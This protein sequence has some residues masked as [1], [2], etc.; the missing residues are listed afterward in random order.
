MIGGYSKTP[1]V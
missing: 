1:H